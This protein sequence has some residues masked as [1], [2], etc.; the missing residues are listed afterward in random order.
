[1][2]KKTFL[3]QLLCKVKVKAYCK[4]VEKMLIVLTTGNFYSVFYILIL[5]NILYN[6]KG[7]IPSLKKLR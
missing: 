6:L 3:F 4:Y 1:M 7:P 5:Y 2:K